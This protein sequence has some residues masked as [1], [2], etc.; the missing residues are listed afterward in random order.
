MYPEPGGQERTTDAVASPVSGQ[1]AALTSAASRGDGGARVEA[2]RPQILWID[3]EIS[4]ESD[5][6]AL[7]QLDGFRVHCA[8]TATAGLAMARAG[9]YEGIVLDLRLPD[10][11][12]LSVLATL[13]SERITTPILMLTGFG[14]FESSRVAGRLGADAFEAKP[15]WGD[16]LTAAVRRLISRTPSEAAVGGGGPTL[17]GDS[18]TTLACLATLFEVLQ[19]LSRSTHRK[20]DV[21]SPGVSTSGEAIAT[22]LVAALVR[23]V[24][25]P[26]LPIQVFLACASALR[27]PA[28]S[29]QPETVSE[30][31]ARAE[32][33]ILGAV[34]RPDPSDPRVV[35]AIAQ[36]E[37][38]AT[39][40]E[41]LTIERIAETQR[42]DPSHL[43]RL[44]KTETGFD[45]TEWRTAILLRPSLAALVKTDEDV[46][47][48]ARIL[49]GF[50]HES[51]YNHE[52]CR[53][54]GLSPTE[55]RQIWRGT[56]G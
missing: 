23:A 50:R 16:D 54:F 43:G 42:I 29:D 5:T 3:D 24:A 31:V 4:P 26:A 39:R 22:T 11:S 21:A 53:Y 27:G 33:L 35:T 17:P 48:I 2:D 28:F 12:G 37:S 56:S 38:A 32:A 41:R 46:K 19:R 1:R 36:L 6:V 15:L 51:Q 45:S 30:R 10:M 44:I 47:Q 7:L 34:G 9:R 18:R 52:F 20:E 13:R 8:A 25:D 14:D 40:H 55:F 49:L